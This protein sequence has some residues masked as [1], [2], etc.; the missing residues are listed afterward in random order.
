MPCVRTNEYIL[1]KNHPQIHFGGQQDNDITH[2]G[3]GCFRGKK[4]PFSPREI[5]VYKKSYGTSDRRNKKHS[6]KN[7]QEAK[8]GMVCFPQ[9]QEP[10][11]I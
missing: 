9:F 7:E 6:A 4:S 5:A 2:R 8:R 11:H 3:I 1:Y 10:Y